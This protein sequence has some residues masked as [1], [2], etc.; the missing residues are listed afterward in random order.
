[1]RK[2]EKEEFTK[3]RALVAQ[4]RDQNTGDIKDIAAEIDNRLGVLQSRLD[5]THMNSYANMETAFAD[6]FI[7]QN[8]WAQEAVAKL[9][10][11]VKNGVDEKPDEWTE[12]EYIRFTFAEN[13]KQWFEGLEEARDIWASGSSARTHVG[14]TSEQRRDIVSGLKDIGSLHRVEWDEVARSQMER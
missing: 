11:A 5:T 1:M 6:L 13:L 3:V 12:D 2:H 10:E 9:L 14:R 4:L 7:N 8:Q